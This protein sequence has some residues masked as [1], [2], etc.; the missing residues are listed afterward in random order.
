MNNR[1]EIFPS[2]NFVALKREA[3]IWA[4]KFPEITKVIL[5]RNPYSEP[6][7]VLIWHCD[8]YPMGGPLEFGLRYK[9][10]L[11]RG[12]MDVYKNEPEHGFQ[13]DWI[14]K[15]VLVGQPLS[16]DMDTDDY[17]ELYNRQ[18]RKSLEKSKPKRES[19]KHKEQCRKIA[20]NIWHSNPTMTIADM[21]KHDEILKACN[22]KIPHSKTLRRWINDLCPNRSPGRRPS[23]N[24]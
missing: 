16:D 15:V 18:D 12:F 7:Y 23:R 22:N 4:K 20:Q 1:D 14:I 9:Q 5:C 17:W 2:L 21:I 24:K 3:S 6:P 10:L 8:E 19:S 13:D 11:S